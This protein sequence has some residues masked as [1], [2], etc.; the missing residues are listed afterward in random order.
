MSTDQ[1]EKQRKEIDAKRAAEKPVAA[2][3]GKKDTKKK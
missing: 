3:P 1:L 2:A